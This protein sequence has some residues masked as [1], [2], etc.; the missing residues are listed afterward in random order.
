[1]EGFTSVH[2]SLRSTK[3][4]K[5]STMASV[6]S[7]KSIKSAKSV[8]PNKRALKLGRYE[9]LPTLESAGYKLGQ[10]LGKGQYGSV[11]K[12][13]SRDG[14]EVAIKFIDPLESNE[15]DLA[16]EV[17][18][19]EELSKNGCHKN[20]VCFYGLYKSTVENRPTLAI[21]MEFIDGKDA[22]KTFENM[23][24][25]LNPE[26][27]RHIVTGLL[28]GLKVM[29][30]KHIYDE[31]I[32]EA[33]IMVNKSNDPIYV[34]LGLG[35]KKDLPRKGPY[36]C[37]RALGGSPH[38]M[39]KGKRECAAAHTCTEA[40][41]RYADIWALG[42]VLLNI[43]SGKELPDDDEDYIRDFL[44]NDYLRRNG[45]NLYPWDKN[46]NEVIK[47]ALSNNS[48]ITVNDLYNA[49]NAP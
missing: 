46:I 17:G 32:K 26:L 18:L 37:D 29:H 11:Y 45:D 13:L 23:P 47:L 14:K 2:D 30:D 5:N 41:F 4:I 36:S 35:C 27:A 43:L 33:N 16:Q 21:V 38:Y 19:L 31:D 9:N 42:M 1:M 7:N 22:D 40:D 3:S 49:L 20:V 10:L 44:I 48:G 8:K 15:E 12:A 34:D 24:K 28:D 25:P 39:S 6:K